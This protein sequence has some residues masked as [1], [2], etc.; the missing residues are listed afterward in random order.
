VREL[1]FGRAG[2]SVDE[3]VEVDS[4]LVR[5]KTATPLVGDAAKARDMLEWAPQIGFEELITQMV[6]ADMRAIAG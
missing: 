6:D 5:P 3:H 2:L 1:A 4:A